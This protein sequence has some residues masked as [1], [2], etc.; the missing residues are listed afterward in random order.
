M[1]PFT[2]NGEP[3]S[4]R[5]LIE[6][7]SGEVILFGGGPVPSERDVALADEVTRTTGEGVAAAFGSLAR[8]VNLL[9]E[10]ISAAPTRPEEVELEFRATLSK[11]C[12]LW[13]VS[14]EADAEFTVRVSWTKGE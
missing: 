4:A 2:G 5:I 8:I 3:M 13:I 11:D 7:S 9:N 12:D 6:L 1:R 10:Q 14:P